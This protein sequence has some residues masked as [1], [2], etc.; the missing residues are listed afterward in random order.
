VIG[1]ASQRQGI[2]LQQRDGSFTLS[3]SSRDIGGISSRGIAATAA[4]DVERNA[5]HFQ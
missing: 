2:W 3:P 5:R 1:G 4:V